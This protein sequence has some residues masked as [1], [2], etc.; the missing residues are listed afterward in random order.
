MPT[1]QT[2]D[3][4]FSFEASVGG[5]LAL[6]GIHDTKNNHRWIAGQQILFE[7]AINN[8]EPIRSYPGQ[9]VDAVV[10]N[11]PRSFMVGCRLD[12]SIRMQLNI[13]ADGL[14]SA[15]RIDTR[16]VNYGNKPVFLRLVLPKIRELKGPAESIG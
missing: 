4:S 2:G 13:H 10:Q 15:I 5:W 14:K 12:N 7:A 9:M 16:M 6:T 1:M 3:L 8:G 11:S